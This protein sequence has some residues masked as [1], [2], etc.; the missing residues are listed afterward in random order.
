MNYFKKKIKLLTMTLIPKWIDLK[1]LLQKSNRK[2]YLMEDFN[3]DQ[4]NIK[5][6]LIFFKFR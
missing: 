6:I 3:L 1:Q 5:V 2:K 4:I